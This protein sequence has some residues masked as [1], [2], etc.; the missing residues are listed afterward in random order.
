M[1]WMVDLIN[2][3]ILP[4]ISIIANLGFIDVR[5]QLASIILIPFLFGVVSAL[6]EEWISRK[7]DAQRRE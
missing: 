1:N 2:N 4:W 6:L 5:T 3:F 7:E